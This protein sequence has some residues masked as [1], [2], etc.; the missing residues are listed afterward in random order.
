MQMMPY[1]TMRQQQQQ[2]ANSEFK[3]Y[4][5][6]MQAL[7]SMLHT[8]SYGTPLSQLNQMHE[9]VKEKYQGYNQRIE[10]QLQDLIHEARDL[11]E[12]EDRYDKNMGLDDVNED[13]V[14]AKLEQS[15][16]R[17]KGNI[18]QAVSDTLSQKSN[19]KSRRR[20]PPKQL[21][22]QQFQ[23][24]FNSL[25]QYRNQPNYYKEPVFQYPQAQFQN[26]M[27][28][29]LEQQ[30]MPQYPLSHSSKS[31]P[32]YPEPYPGQIPMNPAYPGSQQDMASQMMMMAM[33][34]NQMRQPVQQK[35]K[36]KKK[37]S[38]VL[39]IA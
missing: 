39:F 22:S 37:K 8:L 12:E 21:D 19:N 4:V 15:M 5:N 2:K 13:D 38:K 10:G 31:K 27:P 20:N 35:K 11:R 34:Q 7:N 18:K 17:S 23:Q 24:D 28:N 3:N 14:I 1:I 26:Y 6:Q 9:E 16:R 36:K 33:L 30:A 25:P 29:Q 32:K